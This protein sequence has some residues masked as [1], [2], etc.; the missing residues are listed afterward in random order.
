VHGLPW[1]RLLNLRGNSEAG[2][3][4]SI[5]GDRRSTDGALKCAATNQI[6]EIKA[7][8]YR[9]STDGALKCAA[10]KAKPKIE[11]DCQL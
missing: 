4:G 6:Y 11:S 9:H 5:A 10:T 7:E 1:D 2:C 8:G 3:S